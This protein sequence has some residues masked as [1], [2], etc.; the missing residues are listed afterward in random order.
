MGPG[1]TSNPR[2]FAEDLYRFLH[3]LPPGPVYAV[4]LRDSDLLTRDLAE[5][6]RHGGAR[7]AFG[8]HP[9][10]PGLARQRALF[11]DQPP[12]PLIVRW[13]LRT[14]RGYDE[15]RTLYRPFDRI[16][17][18]DPDN[19]RLVADLTPRALDSGQEVFVI[20]NNKAEG[21]APLSLLALAGRRGPQRSAD[22]RP[23]IRRFRSESAAPL[24]WIR[25][26]P[27]G[28][29]SMISGNCIDNCLVGPAIGPA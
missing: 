15:A 5:A 12:G 19:R 27:H 22:R 11:A 21:S 4:E 9:R 29:R 3:R 6:L 10:L 17:E 24:I 16:R 25:L 18:P 26:H 7:P 20:V 14:N 28:F 23:A 1:I 8:I 13:V 2:R